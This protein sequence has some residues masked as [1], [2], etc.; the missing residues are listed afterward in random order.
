MLDLF[1]L[2]TP[3]KVQHLRGNELK[4]CVIAIGGFAKQNKMRTFLAILKDRFCYKS[5]LHLSTITNVAG[6][7]FQLPPTAIHDF[8]HRRDVCSV[9]GDTCGIRCNNQPMARIHFYLGKGIHHSSLFVFTISSF[10][11]I[12]LRMFDNHGAPSI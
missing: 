9:K 2:T 5:L 4:K 7:V 3:S 11:A 12:R 10:T 8:F 1:E 6:K